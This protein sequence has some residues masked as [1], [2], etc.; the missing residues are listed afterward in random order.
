M[1]GL[2]IGLNNPNLFF[3]LPYNVKSHENN[4]TPLVKS[5]RIYVFVWFLVNIRFALNLAVQN[6]ESAKCFTWFLEKW[7]TII[8][9]VEFR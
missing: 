6:E 7:Y 4:E 3:Y 9:D 5:D 1:H 8:I 2:I